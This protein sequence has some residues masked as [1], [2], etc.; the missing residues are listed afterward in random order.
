MATEADM[1]RV[2]TAFADAAKRARRIGFDAVEL[3]FAHGYLLHSWLSPL[4][5][6]RSDEWGGSLA[7]RMRFPLD[8]VRAVRAVVPLEL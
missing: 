6:K 3:H 2:H 7:S 5:I 8:V 4:A 1:A